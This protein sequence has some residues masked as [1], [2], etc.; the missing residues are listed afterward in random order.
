M[1]QLNHRELIIL[2]KNK[3]YYFVRNNGHEIW[4]NGTHKIAVPVKKLNY[5]LATKI[6]IQCGIK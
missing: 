2:L 4:S 1:K 6:L 3:G 5:K